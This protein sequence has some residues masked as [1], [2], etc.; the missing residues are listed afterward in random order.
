VQ[1]FFRE[2]KTAAGIHSPNVVKV[3][4]VGEQPVPYL[5]MER[6][7][8]QSLS[9]LLRGRRALGLD[10]VVELVQHVGA[11]IAAAAAAG[12]I[13]RDIK[14]QNLFLHRGT[15][16]VLDFGVARLAEHG[17]TLTSGQIVGTPAYMSP[18]QAR[19]APIDHRT[20]IYALA[21]VAYRA[22]CGQPPFQAREVADTIY[23]V[24]HT[25]PRRPSHI[26]RVDIDVELVLA[27]GLA[28]RAELRFDSARELADAFAAAR[29]GSLSSELRARGRAIPDPW[30]R[31]T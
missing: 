6:L 22:V 13:H 9:E 2:L 24:V 7:E 11:G 16:K 23:R 8:G 10:K 15:W 26:A 28:K 17:D 29:D 3:I 19:G 4:A 21:A 31:G 18:E 5:V 25:A 12:V 20:D 27:I 1:R 30:A 14:P